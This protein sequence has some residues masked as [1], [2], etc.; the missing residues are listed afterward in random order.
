MYGDAALASIDF[1]RLAGPAADGM[2]LQIVFNP[3]IGPAM[4]DFFER[5]KARFGAEPDPFAVNCYITGTMLLDIAARQA[6][7]VTRESIR[8]GLDDERS[9][10]SIAG[11]LTY[12]PASREWNFHFLPGT[13][14]QGQ[15]KLVK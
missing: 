12:D 2:K 3:A 5:Y 14:D 7:S 13:V 1:L 9:I 6:P 10:E 8:Q 15:F 4:A 11:N